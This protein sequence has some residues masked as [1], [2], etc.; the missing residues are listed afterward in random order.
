MNTAANYS[1]FQAVVVDDEPLPRAHLAHL[2]R[3]AGVGEVRQADGAIACLALYEHEENHPDWVFLDV[4]MPG[5]DGLMLADA[6][7]AV[8]DAEGGPAVVFI[9][10]YEDYA[11]AAFERAAVDYLLKPVERPRLADTL[12]RLSKQASPAA[13][14]APSGPTLQRLP[15]RMDYAVRLIDV[16]DIV[17]AAA[18]NKHVQVI[19]RDASYTTNY[20]LTQLE[21]RL[22]PVLFARVHDSWI[23]ALAEIVEIHNLGGQAYQLRMRTGGRQVPVSR[24]RLPLIQQ[25]LGL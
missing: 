17:A 20:T 15:I 5:M 24:R 11:V 25:R 2:L 18:V 22:P 9:T 3:E 21:A 6:L 13:A 23:V 16:G 14:L 12:Q 1:Q 4:R 19:T 7:R 10:G 8:P